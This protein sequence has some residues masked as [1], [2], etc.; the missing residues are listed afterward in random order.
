NEACQTEFEKTVQAA[1]EL[2]YSVAAKNLGVLSGDIDKF[3]AEVEKDQQKWEAKAKDIATLRARLDKL[4][5][6]ILSSGAGTLGK[7]IRSA[8]EAY[9]KSLDQ[10]NNE[11]DYKKALDLLKAAG[12]AVDAVEK[13]AQ[14]PMP[15]KNSTKSKP[16]AEATTQKREPERR[17][18]RIKSNNWKII[19]PLIPRTPPAT[20]SNEK[21][22]WR[23]WPILQRNLPTH[24]RLPI[25]RPKGR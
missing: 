16:W 7:E 17:S 8:W 25:R 6:L 5:S 21:R 4:N 3:I 15:V 22:T 13:K 10:A 20:S 14:P 12:D 11:K 9:Q 19:T 24:L 18:I 1:E 23:S 2:K